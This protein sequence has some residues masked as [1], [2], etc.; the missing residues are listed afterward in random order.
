MELTFK[1]DRF[2]YFYSMIRPFSL[3][4]HRVS[5][6][7]LI[8]VICLTTTNC[9]TRKSDHT[10][11]EDTEFKYHTT[12]DVRFIKD[13]TLSNVLEHANSEGN[14][15]TF[16][17]FYTDWCLPCQIMDETVF[18]NKLVSGYLNDNFINFKVNAESSEGQDLRFIFQVEEFPTFLF[19]DHR[20]RVVLKEKGS[21]SSSNMMLL[22][23]T[24]IA[25]YDR[26]NLEAAGESSG[27][28]E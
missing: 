23:E 24:A 13:N 17:E 4:P 6:L 1:L 15:L 26:I 20:G 11:L 18:V 2:Y 7:L 8:C 14:K 25:E 28:E 27:E 22:A 16:V 9:K 10:S 3:L 12:S 21:K 19:L 5:Y